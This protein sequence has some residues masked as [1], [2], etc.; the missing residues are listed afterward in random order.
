M[1]FGGLRC[2]YAAKYMGLS[3]STSS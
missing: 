1:L 3:I 2:S